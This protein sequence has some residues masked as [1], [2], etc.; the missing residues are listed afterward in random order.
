MVEKIKHIAEEISKSAETLCK[1]KGANE[2]MERAYK[3]MQ[4][5]YIHV[6]S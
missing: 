5:I 2:K 6:L 4:Y 1:E 3:L